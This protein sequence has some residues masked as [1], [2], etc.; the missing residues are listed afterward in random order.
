MAYAMAIFFLCGFSTVLNVILIPYLQ[1]ILSLSYT[2]G[3][4]IQVSFYC[5][6][7]FFSPLAGYAFEYRSLLDGI[8]SGTATAATGSLLIFFGSSAFSYPVIL[9]GVFVLGAGIAII[10]VTANPY[11]L[12]LGTPETASSRLTLAQALTSVGTV[13][14][15]YI[16]SICMLTPLTTDTEP[17]LHIL[18]CA[19]ALIWL[20]LFYISY[21]LDMPLVSDKTPPSRQLAT[22]ENPLTSPFVLLGMLAIACC[23]G[24]DVA[25]ASHMIMFLADPAIAGVSLAVAGKYMMIFWIGFLIGRIIGYRLL[26]FYSPRRLL[27]FHALAGAILTAFVLSTTGVLSA[28]AL[29]S[30]GFCLSIM[31]PVIFALVLEGSSAKKSAVSGYLCMANI[32]GALLPLSQGLLADNLGLHRSYILPLAAF[33]YLTAYSLY[34]KKNSA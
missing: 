10:Q 21:T 20:G 29:L 30:L 3:A 5:A 33:L 22:D 2:P 19:L 13:I 14:A 4:L 28:A 8:R 31:Y 34:L 9:L 26:N 24:T 12:F 32:G 16:G 25:I 18:Y 7:F 6:Y 23:S 15:P 27:F 11:M 17:L 1:S